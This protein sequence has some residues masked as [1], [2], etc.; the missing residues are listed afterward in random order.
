MKN[1]FTSYNPTKEEK[2]S[3]RE[4]EE[5]LDDIIDFIS[6]YLQD[7]FTLTFKYMTDQE[8]YCVTLRESSEDW[9]SAPALSCWHVDWL[10]AFRM[11]YHAL[12][13]RYSMW[14]KGKEGATA[15]D[16]EW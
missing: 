5:T 11:L 13:N 7:G 14:P 4:M 9:K 1:G 6:T 12:H 10:K 8:C 16:V 3:I 2:A 15:Y